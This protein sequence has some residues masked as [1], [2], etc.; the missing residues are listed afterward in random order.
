[1]LM[2]LSINGNPTCVHYCY[3]NQHEISISKYVYIYI[4]IQVYNMF[5][6]G[7]TRLRLI[8]RQPCVG[9]FMFAKLRVQ[10]ECTNI[11]FAR[12]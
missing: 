12:K 8:G 2:Y 7:D 4:Y 3:N 5:Y 11:F 6:A 9:K 1:M 10:T